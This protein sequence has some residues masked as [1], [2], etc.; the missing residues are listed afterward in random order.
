MAT[1]SSD[2]MSTLVALFR[3]MVASP[4]KKTGEEGGRPVI[5][6]STVA[7]ACPAA[8]WG[9]QLSTPAADAGAVL[10]ISTRWPCSGLGALRIRSPT[11]GRSMNHP[12]LAVLSDLE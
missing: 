6:L 1:N 11:M 7:R 8:A 3:F 10:G 5:M 4:L 2:A 9:S 12:R